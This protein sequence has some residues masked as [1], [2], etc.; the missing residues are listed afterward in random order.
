[1]IM[2]VKISMQF[3]SHI[4]KKVHGLQ[5]RNGSLK[6]YFNWHKNCKHTLCY[7]KMYLTK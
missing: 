3:F 6:P 5:A 2:F 7:R 1:M 4:C